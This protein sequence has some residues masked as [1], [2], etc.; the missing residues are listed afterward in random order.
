MPGKVRNIVTLGGPHMGVAA[1]PHCFRGPVCAVINFFV[2]KVIYLDI[3]QDLVAP[4]GYFRDVYNLPL[5]ERKSV[6]LPA[7][8]NE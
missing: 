1:V 5:Y 4:A 6:F 7:L 8:N 2:R 3:V